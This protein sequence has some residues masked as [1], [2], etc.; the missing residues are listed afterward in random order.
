MLIAWFLAL[1]WWEKLFLIVVTGLLCALLLAKV[2]DHF[3][4]RRDPQAG[5]CPVCGDDLTLTKLG[6]DQIDCPYFLKRGSE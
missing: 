3:N 2:Y 5:R 4:R 1:P 6:C